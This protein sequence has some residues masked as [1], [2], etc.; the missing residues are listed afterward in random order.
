[1]SALMLV[2]ITGREGADLSWVPDYQANVPSIVERYGGQYVGVS[3][4][5]PAAVERI[6]GTATPPDGIFIVRFP[7]MTDVEGFLNS[8]EYAPYRDARRLTTD[9]NIFAFEN[10]D[11]AP[12][13]KIDMTACG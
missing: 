13:F 4:G 2:F 10:F 12:H 9:G 6:E 11:D 1:M 3:K 7:S 5:T 8:P